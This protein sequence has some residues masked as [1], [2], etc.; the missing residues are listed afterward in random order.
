MSR[1]N[2]IPVIYG[3][4]VLPESMIFRGGAEQKVRPIVFQIYLICAGERMILA[5]AGCETMPG[6]EMRDFIGPTAALA[7][8]HVTPEDITDVVITHTHHD[9]VECVNKFPQSTVYVQEE[10]YLQGKAYFA[11][12]ERIVLFAEEKQICPGVT[13]RK[14]GGHSVG[15]C[16]IE[17][18]DGD[19][20]YVIVGDECYARECIQKQIPTGASCS[21]KKSEAFLKR[22]PESEYQIL[23]SHDI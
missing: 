22:Y 11:N 2:I 21:P 17:V 23:L 8:Y 12:N 16:V 3:K 13:V 6:F 7:Q 14:I 9:H 5:D 10:E 18:V 4:S 19:K 15:S 1:V 20:K